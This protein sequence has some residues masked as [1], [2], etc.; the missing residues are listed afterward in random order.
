MTTFCVDFNESYLSTVK[1]QLD[2]QGK[3]KI[4]PGSILNYP[5][6]LQADKRENTVSG[7]KDVNV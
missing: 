1:N 2:K 6:N 5:K 4:I 7:E 3:K